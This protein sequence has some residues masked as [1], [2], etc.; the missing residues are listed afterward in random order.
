MAPVEIDR[1]AMRDSAGARLAVI[2]ESF[3][4]LAGRR[5]VEATGSLERA[6]WHAPRVILAHD[7]EPDPLLFYANRAGLELFQMRADALIGLPSHRT[8]E[9]ALRAQ[10][11]ALFETLE[12]DHIVS[13]YSGTRVSASG[14]RFTIVDASVWNLVDAQGTRHGQAASFAEWRFV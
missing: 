8:V 9:P 6:M 14:R 12:R 2:A 7:T 13:G 5:L 10:R 3:E 4:R 11:A 1:V